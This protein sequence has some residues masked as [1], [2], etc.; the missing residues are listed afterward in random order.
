MKKT[1]QVLGDILRDHIVDVETESDSLLVA[2][3][4]LALDDRLADAENRQLGYP[5]LGL[6]PLARL[7]AHLPVAV[8]QTIALRSRFALL[9]SRVSERGGGRQ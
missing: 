7:L 3:L 8:L 2:S 5:F 9:A 1:Y 4:Q 6:A